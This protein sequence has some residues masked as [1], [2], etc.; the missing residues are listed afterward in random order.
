MSIRPTKLCFSAIKASQTLTP[1]KM[2]FSFQKKKIGLLVLK[3]K[4]YGFWFWFLVF[5]P[6]IKPFF[7]QKKSQGHKSAHVPFSLH[8]LKNWSKMTFSIRF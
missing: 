8:I 6:K 3:P 1:K 4:K 7:L 2:V 5:K